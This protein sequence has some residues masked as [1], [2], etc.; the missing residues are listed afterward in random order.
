MGRYEDLLIVGDFNSECTEIKM[1]EFCNVYGFHNLIKV[2][3]CYKN[4]L[5][6]SCIDLIL[7]NKPKNFQYSRSIEV[8]LSDHHK[9][10]LSVLKAFV[11]KQAPRIIKYRDFKNFDNVDFT[12]KLNEKL[13]EHK[14]TRISY[15]TFQQKF[16]NLLNSG[17]KIKT[18]HVRAN[19]A[20]YMNKKLTKAIMNRSRYRNSFLKNPSK[21]NKQIYNQHRNYCVNLLRREKKKYYSNLNIESITDS[22]KF[23]KTMKPFFSNKHSSNEKIILI[24]KEQIISKDKVAQT[25]NNYF[26]NAVKLLE[27][28][29]TSDINCR[30]IDNILE[31]FKDHPSI[32][33]IN[34]QCQLDEPF[35][36]SVSNTNI[37]KNDMRKLNPNKPTTEGNIPVKVLVD[38]IETCA[39]FISNIYNDAITKNC[40][41]L[42]DLKMADMSPVF[43]KDDKTCKE[44]Y[45]PISVLPPVSKIFESRMYEDIELYM[46][47]YFSPYLCGFRKGYSTQHCLLNLIER[48]KRSLDK[49]GYAAAILTD[50]SKAFD[51]INHDLL[52]A[53][54]GAYGFS[55]SS[56][57]VIQSYLYGRK[58]RTKVNNS[59]S[60]WTSP[61]AGVPQG[62][63]LGPI[64]LNIYLNDSLYLVDE[65]NL[66]NYADDNTPFEIGDCLECLLTKIE[67]DAEI[68]TKWFKENYLKLNADKCH[69]FVPRQ[70]I[71]TSIKVEGQIIEGEQS[72]KILGITIDK[73]L[74][75]N[76]HVSYLCNKANQKLHALTRI[77]SYMDKNKLKLLMRAFIESLFNY[78]PL[79]WMYHNRTMNNRINR[80]HERALRIVYSDTEASFEE[81]L[82]I[83]NSVTI[84]QRNLQRLAIEIFKVKN[85]LSPPFMSNIFVENQVPYDLRRRQTFK[86][87]NVKSVYNGSETISFRGPE[88]WALVPESIKT[89]TSLIEFKNKIKTWWPEGCTCRLCKTY[90]SGIGFL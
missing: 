38:N 59:Y 36:F 6:P 22:K 18:K 7:T 46:R 2:P 27:L 54:L 71:D 23:W 80:I 90:M 78:C 86:T 73:N 70:P 4:P 51:C 14:N 40:E 82:E 24:E 10:V 76:T 49:Q 64:L 47:K 17:A 69:L 28:E 67:V 1:S 25:F 8:G 84:H 88:V 45:R 11:P 75:V 65:E 53:K 21:E 19:N 3:T 43:K 41:F 20:P 85:N 52:I 89:S 81:L 63:I 42:A 60:S 44:N 34:S 87:F 32:R 58:Q 26:S 12:I 13:Q 9:M 55:H 61:N 29:E 79:I 72:V 37:I 50:L 15:S 35:N 30:S 56:L 62:S 74:E 77:A 48:M 66:A 33:K 39:P 31:N 16:M 83:D 57:T 5:N 68:L